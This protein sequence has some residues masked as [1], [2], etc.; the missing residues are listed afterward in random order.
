MSA[1]ATA[2]LSEMTR[3]ELESYADR[4]RCLFVAAERR[5]RDL[6]REVVTMRAALIRKQNRER[7]EQD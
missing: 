3:A 4:L 2:E 5:A 7:T 1:L 6:E